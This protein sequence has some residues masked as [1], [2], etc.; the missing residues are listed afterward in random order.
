MSGDLPRITGRRSTE[1]RSEVGV[2][3]IKKEKAGGRG[4]KEIEK[5]EKR[6][7]VPSCNVPDTP[8]DA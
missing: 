4:A 7:S 1:R 5:R 8:G 6:S 3:L 2:L